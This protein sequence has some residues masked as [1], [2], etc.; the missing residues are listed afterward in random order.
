MSTRRNKGIGLL[1]VEPLDLERMIHKSN[2]A[3]DTLQA[4][5]D[6][7][8]IQAF[9]RHCSPDVDRHCSPDVDWHCSPDVDQNC[10]STVD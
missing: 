1:L 3:V 7:V 6:S 8:E 5:I 2:R 9:D 4:V 10:S